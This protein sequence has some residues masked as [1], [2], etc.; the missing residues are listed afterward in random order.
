M[1]GQTYTSDPLAR[2]ATH[3]GTTMIITEIRTITMKE[4]MKGVIPVIHTTGQIEIR[5]V[6]DRAVGTIIAIGD[7]G[8]AD[9]GM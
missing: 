4:I 2:I 3:T 1:Q 7:S 8:H 9:F 6:T 5:K